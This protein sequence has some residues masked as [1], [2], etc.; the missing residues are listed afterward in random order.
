MRNHHHVIGV[1]SGEQF[2]Q[3]A[4]VGAGAAHLLAKDAGAADGFEPFHLSH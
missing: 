2:V 1:E 3:L 4:P